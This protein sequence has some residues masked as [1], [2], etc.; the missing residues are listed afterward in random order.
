MQARAVVS[1]DG[2][3]G[4]QNNADALP[5]L[6]FY[7]RRHLRVPYSRCNKPQASGGLAPRWP[8]SIS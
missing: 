7:D 2:W 4:K 6:P 1:L 8:F 5:A 3:E